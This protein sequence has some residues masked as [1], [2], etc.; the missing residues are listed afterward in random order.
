MFLDKVPF[1]GNG[2][3]FIQWLYVTTINGLT[4]TYIDLRNRMVVKDVSHR[5]Q[6]KCFLKI[7][8]KN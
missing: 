3:K 4:G 6:K 7:G 5:H 8:N 2:I 1:L